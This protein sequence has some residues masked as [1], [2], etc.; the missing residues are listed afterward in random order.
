MKGRRVSLGT[1]K[2]ERSGS[3]SGLLSD[4]VGEDRGEVEGLWG[5]GC[6]NLRRTGE[7]MFRLAYVGL[8]VIG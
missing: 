3:K 4:P 6:Q 2:D 8:H 5:R 1:R 7:K